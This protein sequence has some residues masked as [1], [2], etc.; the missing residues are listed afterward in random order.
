M[1]SETRFLLVMLGLVVILGTGLAALNYYTRPPE[2]PKQQE[3]D[4]KLS[5]VIGINRPEKGNAD[6]RVVIVEFSDLQCPQC[7]NGAE[8]VERLML[9][10][11]G[12]IRTVFRHFPLDTHERAR[13]YA[14]AL[15][16]ANKQGKFWEMH[17]LIFTDQYANEKKLLDFARSLGL[18]IAKFQADMKSKEVLEAVD[19]D[20]REGQRL[21]VTS[22]PT[23]FLFVGD[24]GKMI[25]GHTSLVDEVTRI[26]EGS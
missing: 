7:R 14:Q 2:P 17:D 5:D 12:K 24:K 25:R 11:E 15:E 16:A 23:Y 8:T 9:Q 18:D 26:M 20:L 13:L 3:V 21:G 19:N 4:F 6:A 1:K 22:T 10:Y